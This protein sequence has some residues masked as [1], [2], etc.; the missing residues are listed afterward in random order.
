MSTQTYFAAVIGAGI[1]GMA[2]AKKLHEAGKSVIV[3]EANDRVGG[4]TW[5]SRSEP[6]GPV[7]FGGMYIGT[8]H[9]RLKELGRDLGLET[10]SAVAQGE[11]VY[12]VDGSRILAPEGQ[13]PDS[14]HFSR[15]LADSFEIL[16]AISDEVGWEAPWS[17]PRASELDRMTVAEWIESVASTNAVKMLQHHA[18]NSVLGASAS[19]V[20]MLYWAYYVNQCEGIDSLLATR[21][22]AQNEWWIG[23][24]A[25]ISEKIASQLAPNVK[26]NFPV[27]RIDVAGEL[28]SIR[29]EIGEQVVAS[30]V[31]L[32]MS[33]ANAHRIHFNPPLPEKRAQL[34]MRAPMA[35]MAKVVMRFENAFWKNQGLS[36]VVMD[37]EQ[38]G[39]LMFPGTKPTDTAKTLIGF[40]GGEY[41]DAWAGNDSAGRQQAIRA[42]LTSAF[43]CEPPEFVYYNETDWTH[44]PWAQGG[45]VTFFPPGVMTATGSALR[46]SIGQIH[47]AGTEASTMWSGY[48]EG[49]VRAGLAAAESLLESAS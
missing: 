14:V 29:S 26:L 3:L 1:S 37:S 9:S 33:P 35:R 23:G 11:D 47:F 43:D 18:V 19:E 30:N 45:P 8:S 17:S 41:R 48:L 24:T 42:L 49:G 21:G 4:R 16:N 28:V 44:Q 40:I 20:S 25:Q 38:L 34:Q 36:G 32:A 10:T 39:I 22:G 2:A 7:D 31:V 46:D 5:S 27:S 15:E 13:I 6:G 12:L